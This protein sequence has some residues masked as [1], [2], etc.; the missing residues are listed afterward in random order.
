MVFEHYD[1]EGFTYSTDTE[2]DNAEAF[3][4]GAARPDLAWIS[5]DRDVWHANPFYKGPPQP[6]PEDDH[7][8]EAIEAGHP[9]EPPAAT[10][11]ARFEPK[12]LDLNDEI[13]F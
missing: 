13:P 4:L 2:W 12:T 7:A 3:E 6:H 1:D 10:Y 11:M 8:W 5:T 9:Y